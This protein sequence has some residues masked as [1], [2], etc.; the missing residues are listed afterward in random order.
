MPAHKKVRCVCNGEPSNKNMM[1][2]GHTFTKMLDYMNTRTF[3]AIVALKKDLV[4]GAD[5]S[6]TF[7]EA[8]PPK[9]PLYVCVNTPFNEW[10]QQWYNKQIPEGYVLPVKRALRGHQQAQRSWGK[11]VD[12]IMRNKIKLTS[13][14]HEPCLYYGVFKGKQVLFLRQVDDFAVAAKD[15]TACQ[16][17]IKAINN[18]LSID[19]KDL[20]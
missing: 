3:W 18:E 12:R 4:W 5:A 1:I 15:N 8:D 16:E 10:Y 11:V 2:F 14:T 20:G 13:T 7:A 17:V 6:Y 19:I 9:I